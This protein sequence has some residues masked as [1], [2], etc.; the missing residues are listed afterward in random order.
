MVWTFD[1]T[2][3]WLGRKKKKPGS[4]VVHKTIFLTKGAFL[5]AT[6]GIEKHASDHRETICSANHSWM[7]DRR[8]KRRPSTWYRIAENNVTASHLWKLVRRTKVATQHPVLDRRTKAAT[9]L[10][11]RK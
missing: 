3:W 6:F 4:T 1:Q 5:H 8:T 2:S 7:L 11:H 9:V 10:D